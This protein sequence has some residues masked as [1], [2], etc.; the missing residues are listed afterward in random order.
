MGVF[1][2]CASLLLCMHFGMNMLLLVQ[3]WKQLL[4]GV[5]AWHNALQEE[6]ERSVSTSTRYRHVNYKL[7]MSSSFV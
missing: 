7:Q 4:Q 3:D 1:C 6:L 5:E 2:I